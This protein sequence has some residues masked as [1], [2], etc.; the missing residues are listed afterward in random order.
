MEF[1]SLFRFY[2]LLDKKKQN[3]P[4]ALN[5]ATVTTKRGIG[6]HTFIISY[7]LKFCFNLGKNISGISI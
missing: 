1:F 4:K 6:E 2:G 7:I 3:Q 5:F